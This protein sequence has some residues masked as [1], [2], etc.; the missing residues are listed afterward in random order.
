MLRIQQ[1]LDNRFIYSGEVVILARAGEASLSDLKY[2][3]DYISPVFSRK[4][5][6][7]F[8]KLIARIINYEKH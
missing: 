6:W 8:S 7:G 5:Y 2:Y 3:I 4:I 1:C